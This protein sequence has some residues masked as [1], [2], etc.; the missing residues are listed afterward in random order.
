MIMKKVIQYYYKGEK[1]KDVFVDKG[2][3]VDNDFNRNPPSPPGNW[4][5]FK[6]EY[7]KDDYEIP[8]N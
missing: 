8:T 6:T 7:V 5:K 1:V 3:I 2:V 4:D